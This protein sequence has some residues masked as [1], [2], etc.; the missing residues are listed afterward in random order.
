MCTRLRV[1]SRLVLSGFLYNTKTNDRFSKNP[2]ISNFMKIYPV[3]I[4]LLHW[5]RRDDGRIM[6]KL[7]IFFAILRTR[8]KTE[9]RRCTWIQNLRCVDNTTVSNQNLRC[10]DNTTVSNQN[11]RCVDNTTVSNQVISY[12]LSKT[13]RSRMLDFK[14]IFTYVV[15]RFNVGPG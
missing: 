1:K 6:T 4:E 2:Q 8:L 7:T 15:D 13:Q 11:L 12:G 14:I 3:G 9:N 5:D 10:V